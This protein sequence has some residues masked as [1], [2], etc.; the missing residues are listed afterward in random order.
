MANGKR[1]DELGA[2][3]LLVRSAASAPNI[4]ATSA[5]SDVPDP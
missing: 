5:V 3:R 2:P 4:A 1:D